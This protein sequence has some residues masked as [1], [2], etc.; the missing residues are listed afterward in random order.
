MS[1]WNE[2][3]NEVKNSKVQTG[4][5]KIKRRKHPQWRAGTRES[6]KEF[7]QLGDGEHELE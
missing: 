7:E 4:D 5:S 2:N 1:R 3:E 6:R